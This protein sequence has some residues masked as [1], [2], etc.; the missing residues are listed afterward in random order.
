M[1]KIILVK[2][3]PFTCSEYVDFTEVQYYFSSPFCG[4]E[5]ENLYPSLPYSIFDLVHVQLICFLG[6]RWTAVYLKQLLPS[7]WITHAENS[8]GTRSPCL[9]EYSPITVHKFYSTLTHWTADMCGGQFFLSIPCESTLAVT[10]Q[11]C[12]II[13]QIFFATFSSISELNIWQIGQL[14]LCLFYFS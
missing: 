8:C 2:K 11:N 12:F 3:N 10:C 5:D 4:E 1:I 6:Y 9:S 13:F 14:I 7:N